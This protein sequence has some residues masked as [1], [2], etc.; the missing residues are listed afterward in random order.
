MDLKQAMGLLTL[1]AEQFRGTKQDHINLEKAVI[2][3]NKALGLDQKPEE[4]VEAPQA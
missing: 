1:A 4:K 3:V 2:A